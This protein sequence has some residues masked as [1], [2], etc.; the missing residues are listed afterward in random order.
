MPIRFV[1]W[2]WIEGG[3]D[4]GQEVQGEL[5]TMNESVAKRGVALLLILIRACLQSAMCQRESI[6]MAVLSS[7]RTSPNPSEDPRPG[8]FINTDRGLRWQHSGWRESIRT[9]YSEEGNDGTI[10]SACGNGVLRSTDNGAHWKVTTGWERIDESP[11]PLAPGGPVESTN[12]PG[13]NA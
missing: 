5:S 8:L 11:S 4:E 9:F 10:W 2:K 6:C 12:T 1:C 7:L 3:Q 13:R